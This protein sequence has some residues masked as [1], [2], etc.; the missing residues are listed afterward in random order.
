MSRHSTVAYEEFPVEMPQEL[1]ARA[2]NEESI[3]LTGYM[4]D[5]PVKIGGDLK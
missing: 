2:T 1:A 5:Q 3:E 4:Y